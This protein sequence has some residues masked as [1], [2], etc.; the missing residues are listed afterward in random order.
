MR[1]KAF[2]LV[3]FGLGIFLLVQVVMPIIAYKLW[4]ISLN[5]ANEPLVSAAPS[6][7]AILGVS[8]QNSGSFPAITSSNKRSSPLPY[9]EFSLTVPSIKLNKVKVVVETN[10]FEKNLAHLPGAALPGEKGNV[11]ITGHSSLTSLYK[12]DNFKAIFANL[13]ELKKGDQILVE[14]GG[15]VFEYKVTGLKVVDPKDVSVINPP[16]PQGRYLTLMTCVPPGLYLKRL[17]VLA[18]LI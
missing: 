12:P 7:T 10:E 18:E 9:P 4:E 11:F 6:S 3:L 2:F 15:Q 14:A 16:D 5:R 17:I 1:K 8:I 13:P